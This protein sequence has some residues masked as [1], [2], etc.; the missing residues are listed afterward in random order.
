MPWRQGALSFAGGEY[1]DY[2]LPS[3][4]EADASV[5][6]LN[7]ALHQS[8]R[9]SNRGTVGPLVSE[10]RSPPSMSENAG[11][12]GLASSG[13]HVSTGHHG[14]LLVNFADG[15][16][17]N[18]TASGGPPPR[19]QENQEEDGPRVMVLLGNGR[20][21]GGG[22]LGVFGDDSRSQVTSNTAS[23]LPPPYAER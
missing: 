15:S 12:E 13:E 20:W 17:T 16:E 11:C 6:A 22:R 5:R 8:P 19:Y 1:E 10:T 7:V 3:A 23:T 9:S 14:A 4:G 2:P 18:T 21:D